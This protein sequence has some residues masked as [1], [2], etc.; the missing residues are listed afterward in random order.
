MAASE[1]I[2]DPELLQ[3]RWVLCGIAP[4]ALTNQAEVALSQGFDGPALRQLAG[5]SNP[6]LRDLGTLPDRVFLEMGLKP[7]DKDRAVEVLIARG[8]PAVS[9]ATAFL[10]N[11]FPRLS[12][13][14]KKHIASWAGEAAGDYNDMA[15][16]VHFVV[17]DLYEAGEME[18]T[19]KVFECLESLLCHGDQKTRDVIGIGFFEKL[20]NFA[21]RRPYGNAA[22]EQFLGPVSQQVWRE[23]KQQWAGKS[24]LMDVISSERESQE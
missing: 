3:A 12:T 14:W 18:E 9:D 20:Q 4:G 13:R 5:L 15:E 23:I 17:E 10:L 1:N 7:L 16:F 21:S 6:T 8:L 2:F 22:F 19:R 11:T 24:S